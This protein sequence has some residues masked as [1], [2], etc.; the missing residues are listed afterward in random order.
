MTSI[1]PPGQSIDKYPGSVL[2][3]TQ[4]NIREKAKLLAKYVQDKLVISN[5]VEKHLLAAPAFWAAHFGLNPQ[6]GMV[7]AV[8]G[9]GTALKPALFKLSA[10]GTLPELTP[11]E[12]LAIAD[13]VM[14]YANPSAAENDVKKESILVVIGAL[15]QKYN[16]EAKI[17]ELTN[18]MKI[19]AEEVIYK[20]EG[21][22]DPD[23]YKIFFEGMKTLPTAQL[24]DGV[25]KPSDVAWGYTILGHNFDGYDYNQSSAGGKR[26]RAT[27]VKV[28]NKIIHVTTAQFSNVQPKSNPLN[29]LTGIFFHVEAVQQFY[30]DAYAADP[31]HFWETIATH[32]LVAEFDSVYHP[33]LMAIRMVKVN[34]NTGASK[35]RGTVVATASAADYNHSGG[36][37]LLSEVQQ[38]MFPDV[39]I[40]EPGKNPKVLTSTESFYAK[41]LLEAQQTWKST[42]RKDLTPMVG[43][44]L[45][46]WVMPGPPTYSTNSQKKHYNWALTAANRGIIPPYVKTVYALG[47][48]SKMPKRPLSVMTIRYYLQAP[49]TEDAI[50]RL[51]IGSDNNPSAPELWKEQM[52]PSVTHYTN[53]IKGVYA[54][55][56][57]PWINMRRIDDL[58]NYKARLPE[59]WSEGMSPPPTN[60][61]IHLRAEE[62][63]ERSLKAFIFFLYA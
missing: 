54:I 28:K 62:I 45:Q 14:N 49:E 19:I 43:V 58:F 55:L 53:V 6:E 25:I 41:D 63:F 39:V 18:E 31:K 51:L 56:D 46:D 52:N 12:K 15:P 11:K 8:D 24:R 29:R 35:N 3:Q 17:T 27:W 21:K 48:V 34:P 33:Q 32:R 2:T 37:R 47:P 20:L 57:N 61:H 40:S 36:Y 26:V 1:P 4:L 22:P 50:R 38:K 60:R 13:E 9:T 16:I 23:S 59:D 30:F 7:T 44:L 42:P 10:D 5:L